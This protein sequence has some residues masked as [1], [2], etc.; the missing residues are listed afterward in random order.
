MRETWKAELRSKPPHNLL[1]LLLHAEILASFW[2]GIL[3]TGCKYFLASNDICTHLKRWRETQRMSKSIFL[4][5][6]WVWITIWCLTNAVR[7]ILITMLKTCRL[8]V[9]Q[10]G[11]RCSHADP[12]C[13]LDD[14][15]RCHARTGPGHMRNHE[16]R[17]LKH[18]QRN[19][20]T[21]TGGS[22]FFPHERSAQVR[23][24]QNVV[25]P[26]STTES[27]QVSR[28][29]EDVSKQLNFYMLIIIHFHLLM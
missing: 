15:W 8:T 12:V 5:P 21:T 3:Y 18:R 13:Y 29:G 27:K 20:M 9:I 28:C 22:K 26:S 17:D 11:W 7:Y 10:W 19:C 25:Q 1:H 6:C 2:C 24:C 16:N 23:C 4:E 14:D